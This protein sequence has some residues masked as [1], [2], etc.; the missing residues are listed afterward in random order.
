MTLIGCRYKGG[1]ARSRAVLIARKLFFEP[2]TT[3]FDKSIAFLM[4]A[5]AGCSFFAM[6]RVFFDIRSAPP[7][8]RQ[9]PETY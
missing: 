2:E 4:P 6:H 9:G 3:G 1:N 8:G 7:R 5:F